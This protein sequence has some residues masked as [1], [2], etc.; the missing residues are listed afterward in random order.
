MKLAGKVTGIVH[1]VVLSQ[2]DQLHEMVD[3]GLYGFVTL[4]VLVAFQLEDLLR[5]EHRI[6]IALSS[7]RGW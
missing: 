7:G 4:M 2:I 6:R 5:A 1:L 3:I